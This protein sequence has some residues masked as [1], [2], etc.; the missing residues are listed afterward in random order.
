MRRVAF[1]RTLQ[2]FTLTI[3]ID[4]HPLYPHTIIVTFDEHEAVELLYQL[5]N[6]V[7]D[8]LAESQKRYAEWLKRFGKEYDGTAAGS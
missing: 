8:N 1:G 2:A 5:E 4:D 7:G 6:L 3:E